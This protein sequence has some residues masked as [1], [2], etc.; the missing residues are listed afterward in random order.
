MKLN[1]LAIVY[2]L[3]AGKSV[4]RHGLNIYASARFTGEID[5]WGNLAYKI[6]IEQLAEVNGT[7]ELIP[8][9]NAAIHAAADDWEEIFPTEI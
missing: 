8:A 1:N 3:E 5:E 6:I 9:R 4:K 7:Q 2:E